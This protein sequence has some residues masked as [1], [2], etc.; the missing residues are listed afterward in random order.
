MNKLFNSKSE[1]QDYVIKLGAVESYGYFIEAVN[2]N[3]MPYF[4][5]INKIRECFSVAFYN[6]EGD[7]ICYYIC[8]T[9][10]LLGL[11]ILKKPRKVDPSF[12]QAPK[13]SRDDR[14]A[15]YVKEKLKLNKNLH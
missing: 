7:E 8:E 4:G 5:N 9:L 13:Y 12:K 14:F 2:R 11:H 10:S 15:E 3:R 1:L 6:S